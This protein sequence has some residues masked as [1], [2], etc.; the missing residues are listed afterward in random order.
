[1]IVRRR[2]PRLVVG[3]AEDLEAELVV[4]VEH[5]QTTRRL[6]A[7]TGLHEVLV[8]QQTL[9]ILPDLLAPFRAGIACQLAA[10]VGDELIKIIRHCDLR[11]DAEARSVNATLAFTGV[12]DHKP[13]CNVLAGSARPVP[14][15]MRFVRAAFALRCAPRKRRR[16]ICGIVRKDALLLNC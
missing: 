6:V 4:L 7:A 3:V 1:M 13:H 16:R 12:N 5:L 9:E 11:Q 10:A 15:A 14:G 8:A 2:R